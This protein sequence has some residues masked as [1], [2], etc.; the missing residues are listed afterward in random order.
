V[1]ASE[2]FS[3]GEYTFY[4]KGGRQTITSAVLTETFYPLRQDYDRLS[5]GVYMLSLCEAVIQQGVRDEELFLLLLHALSR[6]TFSDQAWR[7]LTAGFLL[8][9][10]GCE[11][12]MPELGA[13]VHCGQTIPD[14]AAC[15]FDPAEG[16]VCCDE[17]AQRGMQRLSPQQLRWLRMAQRSGSPLWVDSQDCHAP[18][19]LLRSFVE[20]RLDVPIRARLPEH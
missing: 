18:F 3:L 6:L 5:V 11:G 9:F 17:C 2:L 12:F 13:C 15:A 19:A 20:S 4:E 8:H 7:P 14:G 1:A 10:A 16:G